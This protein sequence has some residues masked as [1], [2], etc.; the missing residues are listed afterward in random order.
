LNIMFWP[1]AR[2][3]TAP[4]GS[5]ERILPPGIAGFFHSLYSLLFPGNCR[6]CEEALEGWTRVPVCARC[7]EG[8]RPLVARAGFCSCCGAPREAAMPEL[9]GRCAAGEYEFDQARSF[10]AYDGALREVLHLF[11]YR[12]MRPLARPLG[13][14]LAEALAGE[15]QAADFDAIVAVPLARARLRARGYNQAEL[16][17]RELSRAVRMPCLSGACRR[18]RATPPQ[19][20]L[21]R[22]QRLENLRGAFAPGPRAAALEGRRLL[23]IDDVFTTGATLSVCA[24]ALRRAGA[25]RVSALTVARTLEE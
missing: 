9:C 7:L 3:S 13:A 11:K 12:G 6:I 22:A 8:L 16:L 1:L 20:G 10:G 4:P 25:R 24:Q 17:A 23:L 2:E 5:S 14:R 18:V 15:W 19:T 21:T